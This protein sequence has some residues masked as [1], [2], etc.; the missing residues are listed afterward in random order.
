MTRLIQRL[1]ALTFVAA[2]IGAPLSTLATNGGSSVQV[3]S[4][5][6]HLWPDGGGPPSDTP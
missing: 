6:S 5:G 3:V 2:A 4:D 1:L